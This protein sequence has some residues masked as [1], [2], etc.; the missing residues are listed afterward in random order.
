[1]REFAKFEA[2]FEQ[3]NFFSEEGIKER[4]EKVKLKVLMN[5]VYGASNV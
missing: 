2:F 5:Q 4:K 1:V 3:L